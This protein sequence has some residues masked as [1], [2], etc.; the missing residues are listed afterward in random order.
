MPWSE[1]CVTDG[2]SWFP[3]RT[4]TW[5]WP[6]QSWISASRPCMTEIIACK[7]AWLQRRTISG[8]RSCWNGSLVSV[9]WG[10]ADMSLSEGCLLCMSWSRQFSFERNSHR[11]C[12]RFAW[13][14][15]LDLTLDLALDLTLDLTAAGIALLK[16]SSVQVWCWLACVHGVVLWTFFWHGG[17]FLLSMFSRAAF[18]ACCYLWMLRV[19]AV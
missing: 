16:F 5:L 9:Q 14:D 17:L 4:S 7:R 2:C 13:L 6:W 19:A 11:V 12:I 3:L 10:H 15:P 18:W 1:Q 8:S